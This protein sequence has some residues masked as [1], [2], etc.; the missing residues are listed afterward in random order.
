MV[1]ECKA[2]APQRRRLWKDIGRA[3]EWK[4]PRAPAV[5]WLWDERATKAVTFF[6]ESTRVG[7]V[8]DL[9]RLWEDKEE[10]ESEVEE[11]GVDPPR[12]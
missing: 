6:L 2:W 5:R 8:V 10:S 9:R 3:W 1:S 4:H 7:E 12:E 11:D